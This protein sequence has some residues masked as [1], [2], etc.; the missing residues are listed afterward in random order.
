[1]VQEGMAQSPP[2]IYATA[3]NDNSFFFWKSENKYSWKRTYDNPSF[4]LPESENNKLKIASVQC[5]SA[6]VSFQTPRVW[7][8]FITNW[9]STVKGFYPV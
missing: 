7:K 6:L 2:S 9:T 4:K 5:E 8:Q 3:S 1:M